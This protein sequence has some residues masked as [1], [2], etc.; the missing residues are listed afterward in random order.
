VGVF[1]SSAD[2]KNYL[3]IISYTG[4]NNNYYSYTEVQL[5]PKE[6]KKN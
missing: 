5:V 4:K 2:K 1:E 3:R 6:K